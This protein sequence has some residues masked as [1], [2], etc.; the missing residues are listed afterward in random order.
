MQL[1]L[2]T[3]ALALVALTVA[4]CGKSDETAP[5][6][7]SASSDSSQ[8]AADL[9]FPTFATKNTTRVGGSDATAN[10]A[11]TARAI[12]P[13][14]SKAGFPDV[15]AV[16][17][18]DDWR[19]ALASAA[20][21]ADPINAPLLLSGEDLPAASA[22]ALKA[23]NPRGLARLRG[24][25]VIQIGDVS[26]PSDLKVAHVS[27]KGP[28]DIAVAL[29]KLRR[30]VTRQGTNDFLVVSMDAPQYAMPAAAWAARSGDPILFVNSDGIPEATRQAIKARTAANVYLLGPTN[31][32]NTSVQKQLTKL[33]AKVTRIGSKDPVANAVSF[34]RFADGA[35]GW[36]VVDPGHGL[37]FARSDDPAEAAA[38][39]ALSSSG[40]YGPL[41]IL[42]S[43]KGPP[44]ALSNYLLDIQPGYRGDP[45][46][47]VYNHG[48][49]VGDKKAISVDT[50]AR[51]DSLLE[52]VPITT[53][54]P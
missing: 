39:A 30:R 17:P 1:K 31:A 32:I 29:I 11:A 24:A 34:A 46:R 50:Q 36:G 14:G 7:G 49:I 53:N 37:V 44:K 38:A 27:G 35:F 47:G 54:L 41:L 40:T 8:A 42:P 5:L 12:Y 3:I 6:Q 18:S 33:G 43:A 16:A 19:V 51:I 20:L 9:G 52:I 45:V 25:Q 48:W 28:A 22:D 15:V 26:V 13:G 4:G 21:E 2:A 23:L 10:A